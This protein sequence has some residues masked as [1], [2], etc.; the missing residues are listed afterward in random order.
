MSYGFCITSTGWPSVKTDLQ[1]TLWALHYP[2][3]DDC[4]RR[5]D[6]SKIIEHP[7]RQG[8]NHLS[9][10][11]ASVPRRLE[12]SLLLDP[13]P[14]SKMVIS[15]ILSSPRCLAASHRLEKLQQTP[16]STSWPW[17][18]Y[19]HSES[20]RIWNRV[21][22]GSCLSLIWVHPWLWSSTVLW[23]LGLVISRHTIQAWS[24]SYVA[25]VLSLIYY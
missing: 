17:I 9:G 13:C 20:W 6:L 21:A 23:P 22:S 25:I 12:P 1:I 18:V 10:R 11:A 7:A 2:S 4:T 15:E 5:L 24:R 16:P 19:A 14:G 3:S 8:E